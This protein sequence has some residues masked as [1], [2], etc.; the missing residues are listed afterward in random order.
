MPLDEFKSL[1]SALLK[2]HERLWGENAI[3]RYVIESVTRL[4]G[5]KGIPDLQAKLD[6]LLASPRIQEI[7]RRKF[8]PLYLKLQQVQMES[9]LLE[10]LRQLPPTTGKIQ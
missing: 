9:E 7:V 4:D 2:E 1:L 5:T 10:L 3:L 6:E 8:E